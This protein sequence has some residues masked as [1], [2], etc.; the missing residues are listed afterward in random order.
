MTPV[1]PIL[2]PLAKTNILNPEDIMLEQKVGTGSFGEVAK[3][4]WN[5]KNV[6]IK[7]MHNHLQY[8]Q[9]AVTQF[10]N[11]IEILCRLEHPNVVKLFGCTAPPTVYIVMDYYPRNLQSLIQQMGKIPLPLLISI[12]KGISLGLFYLHRIAKIIH[13]DLKPSNILLDDENIPK[14]ADFGVSRE[15]AGT[16]TMT[17]IGT[18]IYMAPEMLKGRKYSDKV[19][20]YSFGLIVWQM[21]T[22]LKPF[23]ELKVKGQEINAIQLAIKVATEKSTPPIPPNCPPAMAF[24]MAR[25]WEYNPKYRLSSE[26]L[27]SVLHNKKIT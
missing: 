13:R 2:G 16:L 3:G 15:N 21:L 7:C 6:A 10:V 18:P 14:I 9:N 26:E 4:T 12:A 19:D 8:V 5:K 11:E 24:I 27:V 25:C 1:A 17:G 20:V 22:G 23:A